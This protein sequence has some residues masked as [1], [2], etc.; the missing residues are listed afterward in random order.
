[1]FHWPSVSG[2]AIR[3]ECHQVG[4]SNFHAALGILASHRF[5][6]VVDHVF[7]SRSWFHECFAALNGA[8]VCYVGIRC[9]ANV[10][11]RREKD[12]GDRRIGMAKWQADHVH[13]GMTY[14]LE[15]D[16]SMLTP[17]QCAHLILDKAGLEMMANPSTD[18]TP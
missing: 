8:R 4:V 9:P 15:L 12:R 10:L 18:S 2:D 13:E 11:E 6:I 16:T 3:K 5:P 7:E 14:D 1:M 17:T